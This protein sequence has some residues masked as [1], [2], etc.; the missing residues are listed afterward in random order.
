MIKININESDLNK[1]IKKTLSFMARN[2]ITIIPENYE[3]WFNIF[4]ELFIQGNEIDK[5]SPLE[6]LGIYKEK[7]S[8]DPFD[9]VKEDKEIFVG[10]EK[11]PL[12]IVKNMLEDVDNS[13]INILGAVEEHC[14]LI[15]ESKQIFEEKDDKKILLKALM[16]ITDRYEELKE[17]IRRQ[18]Q[19]IEELKREI[20]E[21]RCEAEKDFLTDVYNR[22]KFDKMLETL[23]DK[24][25]IFVLI[26][27]DLDNF[28]HINDNYGHQA[29]DMILKKVG[30]T[31]KK[32]LRPETPIFRIGGEEFAVILPDVDVKT[33]EAIAER[34]RKIFEVKEIIYNGKRIPLS[35]TFGIT[36]YRHGDTPLTI[37]KRADEALYKGKRMG[38]NIVVV[39]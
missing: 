25:K 24:R 1:I 31:L 30:Q 39:L 14:I 26:L 17:D 34:L 35:A 15:N 21:T 8:V 18:H 33:G 29:G 28:K 20:E 2:K 36:S 23:T 13:I 9:E 22:K 37:C 5:I 16:S 38:K 6:L 7:Y 4:I 3:K 32:N 10:D 19:K 12:K 11:V 27:I